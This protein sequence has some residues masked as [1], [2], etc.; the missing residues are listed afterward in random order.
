MEVHKKKT[1]VE[2]LQSRAEQDAGFQQYIFLEDGEEVERHLDLGTLDAQASAIAQQLLRCTQKGDRVLLLYQSGLEFVSAFFGC[3]YAGVVAV[4][5]YPPRRNKPDERLLGIARDAVPTVALTTNNIWTKFAPKISESPELRVLEWFA[6]DTLQELEKHNRPNIS[7]SPDDLAFLQ[8]TS[9]STGRPKG[10]MVSHGNLMHNERLITTAFRHSRD[11]VMAGWLPLFHDMGLVGNLLQPLYV[12]FPLVWMSP[13][14]FLQ[15]PIRW[16]QMISR[17]QATTS[18]G[19]NFAYNLCIEKITAKQCQNLDLSAWQIAFNGA[20][21]IRVSTIERF[22]E[23]FAPYGFRPKAMYPCYGMAESTLFITGSLPAQLPVTANLESS[24]LEEGYAVV[25]NDFDTSSTMVKDQQVMVS[26][27]QNW[28]DQKIRIVD[29]VTQELCPSDR[30]GEIWVASN[31]VAQGY[32]DNPELTTQTFRATIANSG[33]GPF[34]RT[35]D[36]GFLR[37][38][39]LY[40]SG[41]LKD[42]IIIRGRNHFPQDLE[43]TVAEAHPALRMGSGAAFSIEENEM[44][45]LV[46]VQEVERTALHSL[47]IDTVTSA[48]IEAVAKRH[49]L[50]VHAILLL[51]PLSIP[52]T[53]S[54]KIQRHACKAGYLAETLKVVGEWQSVKQSLKA[55]DAVPAV[56]ATHKQDGTKHLQSTKS[57]SKIQSWLITQVAERAQIQPAQVDIHKPFAAY[58]LDSA[59]AVIMS[60]DL[61]EWLERSLSPTVAYEHPTIEKL[62]HHLASITAG[63]DADRVHIPAAPQHENTDEAIAIIGVGCRFPGAS[64]P[65][66]YWELL[67]TGHDAVG[68][69]PAIRWDAERYYDPR[70]QQPGKISTR[71]GGFLSGID[72]FDAIFFGISPREANS[73][74]PQQRLLLETAWEALEDAGQP[75]RA[76]AGSSTGVFIGIASSE[77][78]WHQAQSPA[79]VDAYW[80]TG[81]A[82][83]IAANRLSYVFDLKG[84]SL[85]VDTACSSSLVAIHLACQSLRRGESTLALAG[86]ANLMLNPAVSIN[87]SLG[88]GLSPSGRCRAFDASADGMVRGEG[89]GLVALKPLSL[90]LADG[91]PIYAVIQNSAVNQDGRSNGIVAPNQGAQEDV[92]RMA[93]RGADIQPEGVQYVETHGTGTLL[94]DPIEAHALAAVL[95]GPMRSQPCRIGSVKSNIGHLEAAAGVASLIKVALAFKHGEIPPSLHFN[96]PNPY[97]SFDALKLQ[98]VSQPEPWSIGQSS[99]TRIAAVSGFG[100][101]GTNAHFV[102]TDVPADLLKQKGRAPETDLTERTRGNGQLTTI[103]SKGVNGLPSKTDEIVMAHGPAQLLTLSAQTHNGLSDLIT[104]YRESLSAQFIASEHYEQNLAPLLSDICYTSSV[105]R[106]HHQ[107]R[108]A[109]VCRDEKEL[110]AGLDSFL[111]EEIRPG[112][113]TGAPDLQHE[114][115][116][117]FVF[118]G[119]RP[120]GWKLDRELYRGEAVFRDA[121]IRC[122]GLMR[123]YVDWSLIDVIF[124]GEQLEPQQIVELHCGMFAIQVAVAELWRS[125]GVE[126]RAVVGHSFGEI[127]A[128]HVAGGLTLDEAVSIIFTRSRLLAESIAHSSVQSSRAGAMAA[129]ELSRP[130]IETILDRTD[131][132]VHVAVHNGPASVVIS[133]E[134]VA[135]DNVLE[136]LQAKNIFCRRY[137]VPG[138]GHSPQLVPV[139]AQLA[140]ALTSIQPTV[141]TVPFVST[142]TGT[143]LDGI[144]LD[145]AYWERNLC[146]PVYF[147]DAIAALA[148][149]EYDIYL[150]VGPYPPILTPSIAQTLRK[151]DEAPSAWQ[152]LPQLRRN[153]SERTH[154]LGSLALLY[155]AGAT[156]AWDKLYPEPQKVISLPTYPWQRSRFWHPESV[157]DESRIKEVPLLC[158]PSHL[159]GQ[160]ITAAASGDKFYWQQIV[161]TERFPYLRDHAIGQSDVMVMPGAA[162]VEMAMAA[163]Q[164]LFSRSSADESISSPSTCDIVEVLFHEA[165]LLTNKE[166]YKLQT[167]LTINSAETAVGSRA[168]VSARFQIFS[169]PIEASTNADEDARD[170]SLSQSWMLHASGIIHFVEPSADSVQEDA[171]VISHAQSNGTQALAG[172]EFYGAM[173]ARGAFWGETFQGIQQFWCNEVEQTALARVQI[174]SGIQAEIARYTIHP[175]LL[176][177]CFQTISGTV[178]SEFTARTAGHLYLPIGLDSVVIHD[179]SVLHDVSE[180]W[181]YAQLATEKLVRSQSTKEIEQFVGDISVLTSDGSVALVIRGL[182]VKRIGSGLSAGTDIGLHEERPDEWLYKMV[183]EPA[184]Y[185][186]SEKGNP[187]TVSGCWLIFADESGV[188]TALCQHLSAKNIAYQTVSAGTL[189]NPPSTANFVVDPTDRA[190]VV[191]LLQEIRGHGPIEQLVYFWSLDAQSFSSLSTA[192][193][194]AEQLDINSALLY[195]IQALNKEALSSRLHIVTADTQAVVSSSDV[196]APQQSSVWGLGRVLAFEHPELRCR[197]IDI[198]TDYSREDASTLDVESLFAELCLTDDESQVAL[199]NGQRYVGR[200]KAE[201]D[202]RIAPS[203][204]QNYRLQI[205]A[206]GQLD[207][208]SYCSVPRYKPEPGEIEIRVR[209]TGVNFKDILLALGLNSDSYSGPLAFGMECAGTVVGIGAGVTDYHIGDEV[210]AFATDCFGPYVVTAADYVTLKPAELSFAEAATTL[211]PFLTAY[212]ALNHQA[213]LGANERVLIHAAAGG[214]GLAAVQIAQQQGAEIFATVGSIEKRQFLQSLGITNLANSRSLDFA[215]E[216]MALTDEQGV[217]VVLNSLV[218]PYI[219]KGLSTLRTGG[220]F[221]EIGMR[222]IYDRQEMNLWPFHK[223]ISYI[224]VD[225][226]RLLQ[227]CPA[228]LRKLVEELMSLFAAKELRPLPVRIYP[229]TEAD[230]AFRYMAQAQHIGKLAI[231]Y[232]EFNTQIIPGPQRNTEFNKDGTYLITGG[233]SGLGLTTAQW[234]IEQGATSLA[235]LARSQP[236]A[237]SKEI[238][239]ELQ[240]KGA[241]VY[242]AQADVTDREALATVISRVKEAM[243][244]LRGVF[245]SAGTLHDGLL[246]NLTAENLRAVMAP[247]VLGAWHLH[248]LTIDC[249]IEHFILF[250]SV[251]SLFGSPGQANYVA[252]NA[253]LDGLAHYRQHLGLPAISINWGP[254]AEVG[255]LVALSGETRLALRGLGGITPS[256]GQEALGCVIDRMQSQLAVLRVSWP[257]L[258]AAYPMI[259]T[260]PLF[261]QLPIRDAA[262]DGFSSQGKM[263]KRLQNSPVGERVSIIETYLESQISQTMG[264][265]IP[266][267]DRQ[268]PL[269]K[270]GIDSL[271]AIEIKNRI[272]TDLH[273]KVPAVRLLAGPRLDELVEIVSGEVASVIQ[274]KADS[275]DKASADSTEHPPVE[276][277]AGQGDGGNPKDVHMDRGALTDVNV[278]EMPDEEVDK[279]LCELLTK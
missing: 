10:V 136:E 277:C 241:T 33:E 16:L 216:I 51:K 119:N 135:L 220:R 127:A 146:Q 159:L 70:A 176:D 65:C 94:G 148:E 188:A 100:F 62:A 237:A 95:C 191:R 120:Q 90:A 257:Q 235:L 245:H 109:L 60:G 139:A 209:A 155:A 63:K 273:I 50:Q 149:Q 161:N 186:R 236:S 201:A 168:Q 261:Q 247:K 2:V 164:S 108:M 116:P 229:A 98:V 12:G 32:W 19:P 268:Q 42:L 7:I 210:M 265:P 84:P 18:G 27:G 215:E 263:L 39:E 78:G 143:F 194:E 26:S 166:G 189:A 101:G 274:S 134:S 71:D 88:G 3:L 233:L 124:A 58:G 172:R 270:M 24:A 79:T 5:A 202:L 66:A 35:G 30:I 169:Q 190:A 180:L 111:T 228:M 175:A 9:G 246:V 204:E 46:I 278:D 115:R 272:E 20:E 184:E 244:P 198:A 219:A 212:Y 129:V 76:L 15:K 223:G 251:A 61:S 123:K 117:V 34:L 239:A 154:L 6:T 99:E 203:A 125:W 37:D 97:I 91:N 230:A 107:V 156:V 132:D 11:S 152:V 217:D 243:P 167:E 96:Q 4:P 13:I 104:A 269:N 141:P 147:A 252:A 28:L 54:G 44:E 113:A 214:V 74:D 196:T 256:Q 264:I 25:A 133:G 55:D 153:A 47:D 183:W 52:K 59:A 122:D 250:S 207:D 259:Q 213:R 85:A 38:E 150:E 77:Y 234:L 48:M 200:I 193:I 145:A 195:L 57:V 271:M 89:V 197:L 53:S 158:P 22:T 72:Q 14:A 238:I 266:E 110:L 151:C 178:F 205:A 142:V 157:D 23:T 80:S 83:S 199:R 192:G 240:Q 258:V 206:S 17:Y 8:Y 218:G 211:V 43:E 185:S 31:S 106:D 232:G 41:R 67:R 1:L 92:L 118:G 128:A 87:F 249:P 40:I 49:E 130:E 231:S 69:V 262:R 253:F 21:P 173:E 267:L 93:Y 126:P 174:P 221:V 160:R 177:S 121:L 105:R 140:S 82:L 225:L 75:I 68:K 81:N 248:E 255:G 165:L 112:M 242:I 131:G 254:W 103:A 114:P 163:G 162:Y 279:L 170:P 137:D 73:M 29:P 86:G 260:M 171:F 138:A 56:D 45:R 64:S 275:H 226:V 224:S 208:L 179:Q 276:M 182:A 222:D 187:E 36:L 227:E 144:A 102:L 181:V